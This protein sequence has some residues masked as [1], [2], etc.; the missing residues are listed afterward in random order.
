[1][2]DQMAGKDNLSLEQELCRLVAGWSKAFEMV[3]VFPMVF[4]CYTVV[5]IL[6]DPT[7]DELQE[8]Q[9]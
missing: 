3:E 1:M 7:V 2:V 8:E 9:F 4:G 6:E 5:D